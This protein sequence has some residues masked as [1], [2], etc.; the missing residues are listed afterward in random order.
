MTEAIAH[1]M[2]ECVTLRCPN[3][4]SMGIEIKGKS[5]PTSD[6]SVSKSGA[7][8]PMTAQSNTGQ[9]RLLGMP[10]TPKMMRVRKTPKTLW[11]GASML[12]SPHKKI[13]HSAKHCGAESGQDVGLEG[14]CA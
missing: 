13:S 2:M 12:S 4:R 11:V 3:L 8:E 9:C 10:N 14:V 1:P 5:L 6:F 7:R